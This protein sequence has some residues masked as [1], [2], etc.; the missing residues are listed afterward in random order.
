MSAT[1]YDINM[2]ING[3]EANSIEETVGIQRGM[4]P[5]RLNDKEVSYGVEKQTSSPVFRL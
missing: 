5:S 3:V 4:S 1:L 2:C